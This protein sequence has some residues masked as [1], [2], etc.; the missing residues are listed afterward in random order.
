[1]LVVSLSKLE[2][3][4]NTHDQDDSDCIECAQ[5]LDQADF[6]VL[7]LEA[8]LRANID[9]KSDVAQL[10]ALSC[11]NTNFLIGDCKC[12][13]VTLMVENSSSD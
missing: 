8:Q 7:L 9:S 6:H 13:Q 3:M 11:S 2:Q 4:N 1:M 10:S 5:E 12:S